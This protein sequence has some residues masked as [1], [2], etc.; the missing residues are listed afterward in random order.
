MDEEHAQKHNEHEWHHEHNAAQEHHGHHAAQQP[1]H[2]HA[3]S[4]SHKKALIDPVAISKYFAEYIPALAIYLILAMIVFW[5]VTSNL[6]NVVVNGAGDVYQTLWNLW[7]VNFATFT[8]HTSIYSTTMLYYPVGANLATQTLSPLA[9]YFSAPFQ[10]IGRAFGGNGLGFGYNMVFFTDFMLSGFFMFLLA[11][12]LVKNKYAA[13][14]AGIIF[15][16]SPMH[17]AQ[18]FS[19]LNWTSIEFL[20]LFLLFFL[21][22]I[23]EKKILYSLLAAISF[24]LVIF[25]GDPEQGIISSVFVFF[26]LLIYAI[27]KARRSE[28]LSTRFAINLAAMI[29]LVLVI[30]SPFLIPTISALLGS[31]GLHAA[32]QLNDIPHNMLWSDPISSFLLPSPFNNFLTGPAGSYSSIYSADPTERVSYLG[33]VAIALALIALFHDWKKNRLSNT[34]VWAVILVIFGWLALGPYLQLGAL[35]SSGIPGIYL[36]YRAIPFFNIIREPGRF[37]MI[38]TLVLAILAAYGFREIA[39][40]RKASSRA[41]AKHAITYYAAIISILILVEYAGVP[42]T[43]HFINAHFLNVQIPKVYYEIGNLS[44]GFTTLVLPAIQNS[45]GIQPNLYLGQGMYYQTATQRP[46]ITGYTSR[47]NETEL[48]PSITLP[49]A[50]A[51]SYLE[52]G[53]GLVY[54][55]PILENSS[56]VTLFWLASYK[57]GFVSIIRQAYSKS[58]LE[59]LGTYLLDLFGQPVYQDNATIVFDAFNATSH[60]GKAIVAYTSD[61]WFPGY[62][63]CSSASLCNSTIANLWWGPNVR[64]LY[65]YAPANKTRITMQLNAGSYTGKPILLYE[66]SASNL[67][68]N[69]SATGGI[70]HYLLNLT[71]IPGL[72]Q[73]FFYSQNATVPGFNSTYLNFGINNITITTRK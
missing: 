42:L 38:V 73:L 45:S 49:L 48:L 65:I 31:Q 52:G 71:L 27:D 3:A 54:P 11:D 37:D 6:A 64:A 12:Y 8:L 33:Y 63:F 34:L 25:F 70:N 29:I 68:A 44:S 24:V 39:D 17:L 61:T 21:I 47:V 50:V 53:Q 35:T 66:N 43:S 56:N 51:A 2:E 67:V 36:V 15:A 55:S 59:Q 72:N 60:V 13:F 10:A 16:F 57:V 5:P 32:A 69:M 7:W 1:H 62:S 4:H 22:M 23:R 40:S 58:E 18:S 20:P 30:G 9:A 28:I 26:L 14:I 41:N 19:H 46:M